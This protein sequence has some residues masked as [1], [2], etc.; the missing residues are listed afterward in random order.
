MAQPLE[1]YNADEWLGEAK[2]AIRKYIDYG[3]IPGSL[4]AAVLRN[5]LRIAIMI[6]TADEALLLK[7]VIMWLARYAPIGCWGSFENVNF[8]LELKAREQMG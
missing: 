1:D 8:W 5:D 3:T 4:L 6:A 7:D 2:E